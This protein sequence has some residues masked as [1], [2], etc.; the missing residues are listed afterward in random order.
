MIATCISACQIEGM[1]II[2]PGETV[3]MD[4]GFHTDERIR[5]HFVIDKAS[6]KNKKAKKPDLVAQAEERRRQF[7]KSL[8]EYSMRI[9]CLNDLRDFGADIPREILD[10]EK[11]TEE[12][13]ARKL[14]EIW[15]ENF[16][17]EFPTDEKAAEK[18]KQTAEA[19]PTTDD[20]HAQGDLLD[21]LKG[22]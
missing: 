18:E 13:M 7:E 9:R 15:V 17:Y 20:S 16:G 12:E 4:D 21:K 14:A 3:E 11:F 8:A 19:E 22:K 1:G 2:R 5:L 10:G 6:I